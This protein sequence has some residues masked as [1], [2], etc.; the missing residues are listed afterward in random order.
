MDVSDMN[1][2]ILKSRRKIIS[3]NL[4]GVF[5]FILFYF[6]FVRLL[7]TPFSRYEEGKKKE[8]KKKLT[9]LIN[10]FIKSPTH[11]SLKQTILLF[12]LGRRPFITGSFR[13]SCTS[14][15]SLFYFLGNFFFKKRRRFFFKNRTGQLVGFLKFF[16]ICMYWCLIIMSFCTIS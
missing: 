13:K 4:Q 8:R 15:I 2:L 14:F 5:G 7:S 11:S 10:S 6:F 9:V 1:R 3:N 16:F 12:S